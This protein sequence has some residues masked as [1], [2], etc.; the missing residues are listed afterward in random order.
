IT[1]LA[2]QAGAKVLLVGDWSQLQAVDAGGAF[3][4]LVHDREDAPE[5]VDVHRFTHQWEKANSLALRHG[6]T[7]AIDTLIEHDR[8]RGGEQDAMI[9]AAYTAW[10][11]DVQA[12]WASIL[13]A[14]TR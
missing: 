12:G 14:E 10:R 1:G 8:V 7:P 3:G 11:A 2:E 13:V 6:R 5:L 4:M 9:D